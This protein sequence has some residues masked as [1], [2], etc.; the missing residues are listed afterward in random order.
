MTKRYTLPLSS[1]QRRLLLYVVIPMLLISGAAIT[2]GLN[3]AGQQEEERLKTDLKLIG[4]A[5]SLPISDALLNNDLTTVQA[6]LDSV[7]NIGRVYGASVYDVNGQQVAEAGVTE[8]DLSDSWLARQ[9]VQT[10][11]SQD[12]YRQVEGRE[13]F[14]QFL[15]IVD[16][17]GRI[18]GL[19]QINRRAS[20]F[21][22]RFEQLSQVAWVSW[23]IFAVVTIAVLVFGHYR[24]VGRHVLYLRNIMQQVAQGRRDVR[25][26]TQGPSEIV[27][28][29]QGLNEMLEAVTRAE[30]EIRDRRQEEQRLNEALRAQEKMAAIGSV[31]SGVAHELGAPLTVIDNRAKKLLRHATSDDDKRQLKAIRGQV[32]RL[33]RLV[34]QLLAFSRTPVSE[35]Q[36]VPIK[37]LIER[38]RTSVGFE[39]ENDDIQCVVE[40]QGDEV[41]KVDVSRMELALVNVLRNAYQ[42]AKSEV[43]IA[44]SQTPSATAIMIMDDGDGLTQ[45]AQTHATSPFYSSKTTGEGTGLGLTIVQHI[46][47]DHDGQLKL[48]NRVQGGCCATLLLPHIG[49]RSGDSNDS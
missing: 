27:A 48:K 18:I 1:I 37:S 24:G 14:S 38:A 15:P 45:S 41:V 49:L 47:S 8:T 16:R 21:D 32:H 26:N 7:F 29:S 23:F 34:N 3:I 40:Y 20:D 2:F 36:Q 13:V 9:T 39:L 35:R 10:G 12:D 25:V 42:A 31:S 33:T 6:N 5:I 4:R 44:V 43:R 19:L 30:H 28:I 22:E 11:V 17:G 46:M